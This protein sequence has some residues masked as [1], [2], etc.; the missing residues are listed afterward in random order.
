MRSNGKME[1]DSL[2]MCDPEVEFYCR[3]NA[4][5]IAAASLRQVVV[6]RT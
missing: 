3:K 1:S 5:H 6:P 4:L 2:F